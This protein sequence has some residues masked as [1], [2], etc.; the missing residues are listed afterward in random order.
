[1]LKHALTNVLIRLLSYLVPLEDIIGH[2]VQNAAV[3]KV[4]KEVQE[5]QAAIDL[6]FTK[7]V[8]AVGQA[9]EAATALHAKRLA[10]VKAAPHVVTPEGAAGLVAAAAVSATVTPQG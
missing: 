6:A 1:M 4:A 2:A 3:Q 7:E 10:I 8:T 9:W 5:A